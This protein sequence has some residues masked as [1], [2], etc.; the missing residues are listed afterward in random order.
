M[1][2]KT[3]LDL[4]KSGQ[5]PDEVLPDETGR[6]CYCDAGKGF[7]HV[8]MNLRRKGFSGDNVRIIRCSHVSTTHIQ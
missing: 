5:M 2:Q 1:N 7:A 3:H 4:L 6:A 8:R